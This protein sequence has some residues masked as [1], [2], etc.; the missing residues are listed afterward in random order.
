MDL[1][2]SQSAVHFTSPVMASTATD[3]V[4]DSW[5]LSTKKISVLLD[6]NNYL[7]WRQQIL[8]TVKTY[9]LQSFLD[10][11]TFPPTQHVSNKHGV[12]HE[13]PE[14]VHFEQQD[15]A[16]VSWLLSSVSQTVLPHLIGMNTS[17][18]IWNALV[19]LYGSKTTSRLM[20]YRRAL[21]SQRKGELYMKE[22]LMIIKGY[23]DSFDSCGEVISEHEHVTAI[24]N[25][26][27]SEYES[28]IT[29]ITTSQVPYH[30]QGVTTMLLDAEAQ[31]H[32]TICDA[33]S[34]ANMV[35]H[36][37]PDRSVKSNSTPAYH[38]SSTTRSRRRGQSSA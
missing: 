8:F 15:S 22:F 6:D 31:Q 20:F 10:S 5:F 18:Q 36:Q 32:V 17:A 1:P 9:K 29:I 35:S 30:V 38:P 33:S 24:L 16:L 28:V 25:S 11:R 7:L 27:S 26:L 37:P 13:N 34:S 23:C 12:L 21:H 4:V 3:G 2:F 14:F 19:N